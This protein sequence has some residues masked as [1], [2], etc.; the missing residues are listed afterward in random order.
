MN[1]IGWLVIMAVLLVVEIATLGL[2]TIWFAAGALVA[3]VIAIFNLPIWLQ[4]GVFIVVSV[5]MLIF[6][7]PAAAKYLN[8]KTTKTNVDSLIGKSAK[9]TKTINNI[10]SEGQVVV[11]GMEWTARSSEDDVTIPEGTIVTILEIKG[12][13]LIVKQQNKD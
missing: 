9:V 13:K 1:A 7:R 3:F 6:T 11:N 2:T 8:S 5:V 12:V 10:Q 4:V